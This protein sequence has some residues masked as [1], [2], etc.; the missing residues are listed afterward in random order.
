MFEN[1]NIDRPAVVFGVEFYNNTDN[2]ET[3]GAR[4]MRRLVSLASTHCVELEVEIKVVARQK[5]DD[6][7]TLMEWCHTLASQDDNF[8]DEILTYIEEIKKELVSEL[9]NEAP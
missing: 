4:F 3:E 5:Y 7:L 2:A 6:T 8:P 9:D 1:S